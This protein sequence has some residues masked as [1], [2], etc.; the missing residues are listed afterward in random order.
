MDRA[1]G[2][3]HLVGKTIAKVEA[4]EYDHHGEGR[5]VS[6]VYRITCTDG[7]IVC[8]IAEDGDS[9]D[10][11]ATIEE[12]EVDGAGNPRFDPGPGSWVD[13]LHRVA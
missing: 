10:M 4:G 8:V 7:K 5:A 1:K 6:E 13:P 12:M 2:L 3:A 9:E 11:Y